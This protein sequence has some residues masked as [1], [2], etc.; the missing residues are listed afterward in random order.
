M[1]QKIKSI[2]FMKHRRLN[3]NQIQTIHVHKRFFH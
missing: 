2:M 3:T 1:K